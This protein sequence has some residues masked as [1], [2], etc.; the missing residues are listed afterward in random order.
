MTV[1]LT[2]PMLLGTINCITDKKMILILLIFY[3]FAITIRFK[4]QN[5]TYRPV[6]D[7]K[8]V[9]KLCY[10]LYRFCF[11]ILLIKL[12]GDTEKKN[13]RK[14]LL[15]L[16]LNNMPLKFKQ[17][18]FIKVALFKLYIYI[19]NIYKSVQSTDIV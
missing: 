2:T 11:Q 5:R 15:G 19:Y 4:N 14:V 16:L 6:S 10:Y 3:I 17:F 13:R 12:C 7:I 1:S 8:H 18:E 9:F